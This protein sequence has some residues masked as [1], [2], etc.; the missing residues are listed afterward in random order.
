MNMSE[1]IVSS[2]LD[3]NAIMSDIELSLESKSGTSDLALIELE[4]KF[5]DLYTSSN[6]IVDAIEESAKILLTK[7][8]DMKSNKGEVGGNFK[9]FEDTTVK[10][11]ITRASSTM[12]ALSVNSPKVLASMTIE[13]KVKLSGTPMSGVKKPNFH[14]TKLDGE[15]QVYGDDSHV[16]D[17]KSRPDLSNH[18]VKSLNKAST[19]EACNGIITLMTS[20]RNVIK[21]YKNIKI[22]KGN[23]DGEARIA[24]MVTYLTKVVSE[25]I[26]Q[27]LRT[28]KALLDLCNKSMAITS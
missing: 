11:F 27:V 17:K 5:K 19:I 3:I 8:K 23:K 25:F 15:K 28:C 22:V 7:S 6:V 1:V 16:I 10:E 14:I 12:T 9:Y 13:A 24:P 2:L 21:D 20:V 18:R 4:K 26:R